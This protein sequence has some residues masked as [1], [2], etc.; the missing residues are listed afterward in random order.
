MTG[1]GTGTDVQGL[2]VPQS[3]LLPALNAANIR[4]LPLS[5]PPAQVWNATAPGDPPAAQQITSPAPEQ[6][7]AHLE[8]CIAACEH[9]LGLA[10][11]RHRAMPEEAL[12]Q[13]GQPEPCPSHPAADVQQHVCRRLVV[14]NLF[15]LE[16]YHI[17]EALGVPSTAI[18][19]CVVPY[20]PPAEFEARFRWAFPGL[21]LALQNPGKWSTKILSHLYIHA[22]KYASFG[23]VGTG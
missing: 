2:I 6:T 13:P 5:L 7:S 8:E 21:F 1:P 11:Q 4:F 3:W 18:S 12:S 17:A 14:H 23:L 10:I 9:A 16:A 19:A 22:L 20:P 15:A